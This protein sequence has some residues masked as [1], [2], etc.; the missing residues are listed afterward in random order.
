MK[1]ECHYLQTPKY[2]PKY[3][4]QKYGLHQHEI[5]WYNGTVSS[6]IY[7]LIKQVSGPLFPSQFNPVNFY[8][9]DIL[10]ILLDYISEF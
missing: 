1:L 9:E 8:P 4:I 5:F 2:K 3:L 6:V 10:Y 7:L